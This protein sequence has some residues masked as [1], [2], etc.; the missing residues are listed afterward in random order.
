MLC[1][2]KR[3]CQHQSR[4]TVLEEPA[5]APRAVRERVVDEAAPFARSTRLA[6]ARETALTP[7]AHSPAY[8]EAIQPSGKVEARFVNAVARRTRSQRRSRAGG[9]AGRCGSWKLEDG[10]SSASSEPDSWGPLMTRGQQHNT[11]GVADLNTN[12]VFRGFAL[13]ILASKWL[14]ELTSV[15]GCQTTPGD[16]LT[17]IRSRSRAAVVPLPP[18]PPRQMTAAPSALSFE[19]EHVHAVYEEIAADFSRT[20][21]SRWPFV[22]RFLDSLAP[23]CCSSRVQSFLSHADRARK[24]CREVSYWMRARG[25]GNTSAVEACCGG[26]AR[27][28]KA[29]RG[30]ARARAGALMAIRAGRRRSARLRET[31]CPSA[32][33]CRAACSTLQGERATRL[34]GATASTCAAGGGAPL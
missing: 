3:P 21:H 24:S 13:Y 33:T 5:A 22:E 34:S 19:S 12:F 7:N 4:S 6:R 14:G 2:I 1:R 18:F 27:T 10:G 30:R 23:V 8:A 31:C 28:R 9:F 15:A 25:T 20:R 11:K 17:P 32:S 29:R 16:W 26:R